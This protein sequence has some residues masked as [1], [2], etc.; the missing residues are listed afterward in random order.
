MYNFYLRLARAALLIINFFVIWSR[1]SHTFCMIILF[2]ELVLINVRS[3]EDKKINDG[4]ILMKIASS[5]YESFLSLSNSSIQLPTFLRRCKNGANPCLTNCRR[6]YCK[7]S[8]VPREG[9]SF[10]TPE[11]IRSER[12]SSHYSSV[13]GKNLMIL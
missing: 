13:D 4:R 1:K 12:I 2:S 9:Y 8:S 7:R 6:V 10:S 5:G 11:P 3:S